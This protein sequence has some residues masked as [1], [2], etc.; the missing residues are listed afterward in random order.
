MRA[1][2]HRELICAGGIMAFTPQPPRQFWQ[3]WHIDQKLHRLSSIVSPSER[4]AA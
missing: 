4:Q 3:Q 1:P 2:F